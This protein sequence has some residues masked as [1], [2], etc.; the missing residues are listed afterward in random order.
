[1][2]ETNP[3]PQR[4]KALAFISVAQLMVIL[5]GTIV[6]IALPRMQ[7]DL[8]FSDVDR[9]WVV[10]AYTLAFGGLLLLGGR[11]GDLLGRKRVFLVGLVGFA[12]A[13]ALGG[14]ATGTG[15]LLGARSLQGVF[16]A[17]LAPAALSL[18]ATS[19]TEGKER[20]TAFGVFSSIAMP[21]A[22]SACSSAER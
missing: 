21:A 15:L 20:A 7:V 5:D 12:L 2:S 9:A 17:L 18:V 6:N 8:G 1:M 4:W 14:A 10:T 16:G 22:R 11:L 3:D 13:S 19:F